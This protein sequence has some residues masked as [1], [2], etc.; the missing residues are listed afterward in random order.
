METEASPLVFTK[1]SP[2]VSRQ[3]AI[4]RERLMARLSTEDAPGF[5]LVCAAAGYG[6]TTLLADWARRMQQSGTLTAWVA[7]DENDD[8]PITFAAYLAGSLIQ[9]LGPR[10]ELTRLAQALRSSTE[11][12]PGHVI[13]VI[14]NAVMAAGQKC[15]L[16]LDDYHLITSPAI[17]TSVAYLLEHLPGNMRVV[18]GSRS[19]PPLPLARLRAR[20][21]ML[22]LRAADLRF[23][24]SEAAAFLNDFMQ[25]GLPEED[26]AA[27]ETRTEGWVTGL[28]L[29]GLSLLGQPDNAPQIDTFGGSHRYL[30]EYL[31]DEVVN[32]QTAG[33]QAF[34][35]ATSLLERLCAPL[36]QA[37]TPAD[38]SAGEMLDQLEQ[39]NLFVIALDD[40]GVWYRYHHLF[41]DFLQ[42]RLRKTRPE[43]VPGIH[44]LACE[45]L[46]EH[47][48]LREAARHAFQAG[49]L[50]VCGCL[51]REAQLHPHP[52]Q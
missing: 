33:V 50:G 21:A 15:V 42:A 37:V 44:R 26:I 3:R 31:L 32:R 9:A 29:A 16:I 45:W 14:I 30:V 35:L 28:Q 46:A 13:A 8:S 41:R 39:A 11:I 47:G 4:P 20:G 24:R 2:P 49:G 19:D 23:T 36:C 6:K 17:H 51:R 1:L 43:S 38:A 25:L 27:L 7:L 5:T 22:E 18:I 40:Q 34:L 10:P 52:A 12:D 48:Y